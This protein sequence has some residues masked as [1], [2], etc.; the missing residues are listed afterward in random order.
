MS[1]PLNQP[2]LDLPPEHDRCPHCGG[3][4]WTWSAAAETTPPSPPAWRMCRA[5]D[6]TGRQ[7]RSKNSSRRSKPTQPPLAVAAARLLQFRLAQDRVEAQV[8]EPPTWRQLGV[9][10][11][12]DP[13]IVRFTPTGE[14]GARV[15]IYR[16]PGQ[17]PKA[18]DVLADRSTV[19]EAAERAL[20]LQRRVSDS[21]D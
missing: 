12:F 17:P 1:L 20:A 8:S 10:V 11:N 4:G 9:D 16:Q 19:E 18:S 3:E 6:T 15:Y 7:L 5:C 13:W 14:S 21:A 2:G